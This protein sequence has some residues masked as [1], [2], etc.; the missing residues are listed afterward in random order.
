MKSLKDKLDQQNP[1]IRKDIMLETKHKYS[2]LRKG[3]IFTYNYWNGYWFHN[4]RLISFQDFPNG[5]GPPM[6]RL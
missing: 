5:E 6:Q 4:I 2:M 3:V 1:Y